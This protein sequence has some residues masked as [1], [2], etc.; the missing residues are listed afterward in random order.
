MKKY[1]LSSARRWAPV[2]TQSLIAIIA[3][4][5]DLIVHMRAFGT[6]GDAEKKRGGGR[7]TG[8]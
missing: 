2:A 7:Y 1:S 4:H 8:D 3:P 6:L 5:N